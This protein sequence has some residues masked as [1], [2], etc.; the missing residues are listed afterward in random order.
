MIGSV[1]G[2]VFG[3]VFVLANSGSLA[4]W[5]GLV[6]RALAVV[7]FVTVLVGAR[8]PA[9]PS[10]APSERGRLGGFGREYWLV[11]AGEV[12]A[13]F[14]GLALLNGPIDA[15]EAAVAWISFVV[16]VHFVALAA[17]WNEPVFS[18][19]GM[20]LALCGGLGLALA[21]TGADEA[22]IDS[23]AG[24]VPGALLLGFALWGSRQAGRAFRP[25]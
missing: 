7:A 4:P 18:W 2:A 17:V 11:V 22:V 23:V 19:L 14:A 12:L 8:R 13:I 6:L 3:L 15:P 25:A 9:A 24:I 5:L 1:I 16:G 20:A 21:A 10:S